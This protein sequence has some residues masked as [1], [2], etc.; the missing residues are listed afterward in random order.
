MP[1]ITLNIRDVLEERYHE[2]ENCDERSHED[3]HW[4]DTL[5][6]RPRGP[7]DLCDV[8]EEPYLDDHASN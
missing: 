1:A 5:D 8:N 7:Q 4:W 3:H 6:V 2:C